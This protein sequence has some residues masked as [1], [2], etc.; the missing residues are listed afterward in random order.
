MV[1]WLRRS[2]VYI[3]ALLLPLAG[4]LLAAARFAEND[5]DDAA[6][7]AAVSLLGASIYLLLFYG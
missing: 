2:F 3:V 6:R 1:D 7:L 5:R 4:F